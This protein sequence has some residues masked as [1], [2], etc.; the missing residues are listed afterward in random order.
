MRGS[1]V[2]WVDAVVAEASVVAVYEAEAAV[3]LS[4]PQPKRSGLWVRLLRSTN[5]PKIKDPPRLL[6]RRKRKLPSRR[7]LLHLKNPNLI[8]FSRKCLL[9][10]RRQLSR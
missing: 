8:I 7:K 5:R 10:P 1:A 6:P 9:V 2:A 4:M 3:L